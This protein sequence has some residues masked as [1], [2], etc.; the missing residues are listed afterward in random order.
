MSPKSKFTRGLSKLT[1]TLRSV[2]SGEFQEPLGEQRFVVFAHARSGSTSFVRALERHP[3]IRVVNEPFSGTFTKWNPGEREYRDLVTDERS[4]DEQLAFIYGDVNGIKALSYQL[5]RE[6]YVHMLRNPERKVIVVRRANLL[7]S[8]VS[9]MIAEQTDIWH[10]WDVDGSLD[11]LYAKLQPLP[12]DDVRDRMAMIAD[13]V[14][15]YDDV[16]SER[17]PADVMRVTYEE[18]Y[19]GAPEER[20]RLLD[21][22]TRFLGLEPVADEQAD[23]L[24]DP[25]T[26]K[27]NTDATYARVPNARELDAELG[28]DETGRLFPQAAATA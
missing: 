13:E 14:R 18:L 24:L 15:F 23:A 22:A 26:T 11:E 19:E 25:G 1:D 17:D 27:L 20:R 6:L 12:A 3:R 4:L 16:L 5:P 21:D 9:M 2:A 28:S 8:V 7:Q 10:S